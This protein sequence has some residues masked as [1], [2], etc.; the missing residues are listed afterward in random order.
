MT[1]HVTK[2]TSRRPPTTRAGPPQDPPS[3]RR[4]TARL[5]GGIVAGFAA[6]AVGVSVLG[7][8]FLNPAASTAD[9]DYSGE[10]V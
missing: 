7:G 5:A 3:D 2:R 4:R 1:Q 8:D 10:T 9:G 6:L